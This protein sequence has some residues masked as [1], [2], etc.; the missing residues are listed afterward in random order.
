MEEVS[1]TM[2]TCQLSL[3]CLFQPFFDHVFT[4]SLVDGKIWFRNY[5]IV[6]ESG[7]LA[8]IGPRFVLNPIKIFDAAFSGQTLWE[9]GSYVTPCAKRALLKRAQAGKYQ[10]KLASKAAYEASRPTE[11]TYK[12]DENEAVFNTI[13]DEDADEEKENITANK[14]KSSKPNKKKLKKKNKKKV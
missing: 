14:S 5:Q 10:Q 11:S 9:N 7:A 8:E 4:F 2:F 12:L 13:E 1:P 3:Y 6:E